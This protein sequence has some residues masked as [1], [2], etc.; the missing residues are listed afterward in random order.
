MIAS[1]LQ[2]TP[3]CADNDEHVRL[4]TSPVIPNVMDK[5]KDRIRSFVKN[6][7]V[8]G[9]PYVQ[10]EELRAVV[11]KLWEPPGHFYS[12]I[13]ALDEVRQREAAGELSNSAPSWPGFDHGVPPAPEFR[14]MNSI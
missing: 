11:K 1:Q 14:A 5:F 10:R 7:P 9:R 8:L 3:V 6:V 12:P 13:P 4:R 2:S